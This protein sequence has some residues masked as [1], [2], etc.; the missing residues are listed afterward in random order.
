MFLLN[1]LAE[2]FGALDLTKK[3]KKKKKKTLNLDLEETEL[4]QDGKIASILYLQVN[5]SSW[6]V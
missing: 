2:D 1:F 3:K 4:Q 5:L 6:N